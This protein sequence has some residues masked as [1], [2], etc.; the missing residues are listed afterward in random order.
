MGWRLRFVQDEWVWSCG[1]D[2]EGWEPTDYASTDDEL[3][4]TEE[5]ALTALAAYE[6][7]GNLP[8]WADQ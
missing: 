5:A 4:P 8:K 6:A 1:G 7:S 2:I 3:Y